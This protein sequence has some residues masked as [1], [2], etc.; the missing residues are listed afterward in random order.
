M[1]RYAVDTTRIAVYNL[2]SHRA[3]LKTKV[4]ASVK[5]RQIRIGD[6]YIP[7]DRT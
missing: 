1:S 7:G 5:D 2:I 4:T 6:V 3:L